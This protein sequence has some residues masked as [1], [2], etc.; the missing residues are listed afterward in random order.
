MKITT[1]SI[2]ENGLNQIHAHLAASHKLGG[3][4]FTRDML[5]AWA[6]HAERN[7]SEYGA[8][9]FEIRAWDSVSGHTELCRI[10]GEGF[11]AEET[12]IEEDDE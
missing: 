4:H 3:D 12:E 6:A 5:L 10:T 8:A 7:L 11:D 9:E 2:N 1:Y